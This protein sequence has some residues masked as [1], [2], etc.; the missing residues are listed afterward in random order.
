MSRTRVLCSC[1]FCSAVFVN[2]QPVSDPVPGAQ[3][4]AQVQP[5]APVVPYVAPYEHP[6]PVPASSLIDKKELSGAGYRVGSTADPSGMLYSFTIQHD[7]GPI[8]AQSLQ[9]M[10]VRLTELE[11]IERLQA[12][13]QQELFLRGM[14]KQL[15]N[16]VE[17]TGKAIMNPVKT[18]KQVPVGFKKFAGE[19]QAQQMVGEVYGESGSQSYAPVKRQ[20]AAKLGVDPYTDNQP[21]QALLNEVAKNQN[22]G[23]LVASLSTLVVGGGAGWALAGVEMNDEFHEVVKNK[24]AA[25]LQLDNRGKLMELGCSQSKAD[26]FLTT[27][28]YT[29]SNCTAITMALSTLGH[30]KGVTGVL[31]VLPPFAGPESVLFAQTQVQMAAQFHKTQKPL[32]TVRFVNNTAVWG[33]GSG[34][35]YVFSPLEYLYWNEEIDI[36][37]S[38]LRREVGEGTLE[39]WISGT[40]TPTARQ[41]LAGRGVMVQGDG[42]A[43]LWSK[44]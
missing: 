10:R 17:A 15:E 29:A 14:G 39:L 25:Q 21:L 36:G 27:I 9:M 38:N 4:P 22:R 26:H 28:G 16:T 37:M 24:S 2:A 1:L 18:L 8:S 3:I 13:S 11:A 41:E 31:D 35:W 32:K 33:D 19:I 44:R 20:L 42:L 5:Q 23:Q 12:L 34:N 43:R 6:A 30:I 7:A 40:A